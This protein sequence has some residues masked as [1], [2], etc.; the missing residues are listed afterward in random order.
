MIERVTAVK[1]QQG[2]RTRNRELNKL[3]HRSNRIGE[4]YYRRNYRDKTSILAN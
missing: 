3:R 1:N 2:A 4:K